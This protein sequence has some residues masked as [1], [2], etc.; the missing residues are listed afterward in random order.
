M[1]GFRLSPRLHGGPIRPTASITVS[2][3]SS[4][5]ALCLLPDG[6]LASGSSDKTIRLWD[7]AAGVGMARLESDAPIVCITWLLSGRIVAG[8]SAGR[9]HWLEVVD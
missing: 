8:D 2:G 5:T 3:R 4:W 6:R 7:A 9:L 1:A